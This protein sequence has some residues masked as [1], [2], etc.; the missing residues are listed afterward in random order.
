MS[1][2]PAGRSRL[3]GSGG[4][5][6]YQHHGGADHDPVP[7]E[8]AEAMVLEE[9]H[10]NAHDDDGRNE[11]DREAHGAGGGAYKREAWARK[12]A[13]FSGSFWPGAL[14]TPDDTSM[15]RAPEM[16]A[17]S[18]R[19]S[20]VRPPDSIQGDGQERPASS[21]QSKESAL[22]PGKA[23]VICGGGLASNSSQSAW[24]T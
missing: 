17:A 21:C 20:L 14:S 19:L 7:A 11:G 24:P 4:V 1:A 8:D 2:R 3:S 10:E 6:E 22:P 18:A 23:L 12:A 13:I 15:T 16:R 9:G 5:P